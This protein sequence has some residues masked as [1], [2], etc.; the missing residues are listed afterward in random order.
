MGKF[1]SPQI[2]RFSDSYEEPDRPD[3]HKCAECGALFDGDKCPICEAVR[4]SSTIRCKECGREIPGD[5]LICP[6]CAKRI[7]K[8]AKKH[9][10]RPS[11]TM[12]IS[13]MA[14]IILL[15]VIAVGG[16]SFIR[17]S[18]TTSGSS[19]TNYV[20][21]PTGG[22][23]K[24]SGDANTVTTRKAELVFDYK[25]K[26]SVIDFET[27]AR[28]PNKHKGDFYV[29]TG[30]VIQVQNISGGVLVRLN[31]TK[32]E[33]EYYTFWEDTI[34][35]TIPIGKNDDRI[36][37]DDIITIWGECAGEYTYIAVL[38][39]EVSLPRID[40]KYYELDGQ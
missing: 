15:A 29:A 17:K 31:I 20:A 22:V 18:P 8:K 32:N 36:L 37:E 19:H 26:C 11:L 13:S 24:V 27:L 39:N 23:Y 5:S 28:N 3:L 34:V 38:G 4:T 14:S 16:F 21:S 2:G 1:G 7:A 9:R 35:A 25:S 12:V 33:N 40:A 10:Q 30:Q 6:Y